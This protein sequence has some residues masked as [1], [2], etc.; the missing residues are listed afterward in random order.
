[1]TDNNEHY[2]NNSSIYQP[3][4]KKKKTKE[5]DEKEEYEDDIFMTPR[6]HFYQG[7]PHPEEYKQY[8]KET[9]KGKKLTHPGY[10]KKQRELRKVM[11]TSDLK[12]LSKRKKQREELEDA[13]QIAVTNRVGGMSN[14]EVEEWLNLLNEYVA[15]NRAALDFPS[16][17]TPFFIFFNA[18]PADKVPTGI[19]LNTLSA[20]A[21]AALQ[22]DIDLF[23]FIIGFSITDTIYTTPKERTSHGLPAKAQP[24]S[25]RHAT[26]IV[27]NRNPIT[28]KK[29][30]GQK[31]EQIY[32]LDTAKWID[33]PSTFR[34]LASN[35]HLT[36]PDRQSQF[37]L[38]ELMSHA[39]REEGHALHIVYIPNSLQG[40][41]FHLTPSSCAVYASWVAFLIANN[42]FPVFAH[43]VKNVL[44]PLPN[45]DTITFYRYIKKALEKK[46]IEYPIPTIFQLKQN[47]DPDPV[48]GDFSWY[49]PPVP[50][51]T[52]VQ[53]IVIDDDNNGENLDEN[54]VD[55]EDDEQLGAAVSDP[56]EDFHP[57]RT[58]KKRTR[59]K[60]KIKYVSHETAR[61]E[62]LR[63]LSRF[64]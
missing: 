51:T 3:V 55:D 63:L 31:E 14:L 58:A 57:S 17:A 21:T 27:W 61:N 29:R 54:N 18:T 13:K 7:F 46:I 34:K 26:I 32:L 8:V 60:G 2:N 11:A 64:L 12:M 5:E 35:T 9:K 16:D 20:A 59:G 52:S 30:P 24:N 4:K 40:L 53:P 50:G 45:H 1:M 38:L 15:T 44:V 28:S 25:N 10:T 37:T 41:N 19:Q 39:A 33:D 62:L 43:Q 56:E 22:S 42:P 48:E 6:T 47:P 49:P 23:V 36:S